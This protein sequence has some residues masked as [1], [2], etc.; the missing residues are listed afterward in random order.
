MYNM[1]MQNGH[2]AEVHTLNPT[3]SGI[4]QAKLTEVYPS[5]I[6]RH[7]LLAKIFN[8][9]ISPG[10]YHGQR[11]AISM[12]CGANQFEPH[13]R[14]WGR[15]AT[16]LKTVYNGTCLAAFLF[17]YRSAVPVFLR[18]GD[19]ACCYAPVCCRQRQL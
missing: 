11:V 6:S 3:D 8:S 19:L 2:D 17:F 1:N 13:I 14:P 9:P 16:L 15:Y 5:N 10:T 12:L 7:P 4:C 18:N